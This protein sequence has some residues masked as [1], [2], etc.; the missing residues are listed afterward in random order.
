MGPSFWELNMYSNTLNPKPYTLNPKTYTLNPNSILL[1]AY[2]DH[3][4]I[5]FVA[6]KRL[7]ERLWGLRFAGPMPVGAVFRVY[8]VQGL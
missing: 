1:V 7:R 2:H 4:G 8:R 5:G 6:C 3:G